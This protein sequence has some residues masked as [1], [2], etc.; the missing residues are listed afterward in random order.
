MTKITVAAA[1]VLAAGGAMASDG[2]INFSGSVVAST[3]QVDS[4]TKDLTV[5]MPRAASSQLTAQGSTAGR[6]PFTLKLSGCTTDKDGTAAPVKKVSVSFEPGPNVNIASGRLKPTGAGTDGVASGVEIGIL[7]D[8]F[9]PIKIG[10]ESSAQ[11]VQTVDIDTAVGGTGSATL[12]FAA[13]YVGTGAAI[14]GGKMDSFV[15]YS[16]MYP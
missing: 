16:L 10:A 14:K 13:Q 8:K 3:C 4:G 5:K 11:Q 6:T 7:N 2:T 12:Q 9:E 15:T 1:L